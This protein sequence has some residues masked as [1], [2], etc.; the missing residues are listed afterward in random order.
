MSCI[1]ILCS[2]FQLLPVVRTLNIMGDKCVHPK[3]TSRER[4]EVQPVTVNAAVDLVI[5][6]LRVVF[7][8][9]WGGLV[10]D[11]DLIELPFLW[12]VFGVWLWWRYFVSLDAERF[13]L[14]SCM[15]VGI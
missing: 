2:G 15:L 4:T 3:R 7:V 5:E 13:V 1:R 9:G 12:C 11:G 10:L 14:P 8:W 6:K